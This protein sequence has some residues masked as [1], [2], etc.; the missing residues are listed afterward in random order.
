MAA[1]PASVPPHSPQNFA[2]GGLGVPQAGHAAMSRWPQFRQNF[3]PGSLS[4]PQLEQVTRDRALRQSSA[5]Y[6]GASPRL[7]TRL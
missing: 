7:Q 2:A 4:A 1:S 3:R 6:H 5:Q